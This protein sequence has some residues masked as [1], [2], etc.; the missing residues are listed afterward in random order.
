MGFN[1]PASVLEEEQNNTEVVE[2]TAT[3]PS[4]VVPDEPTDNVNKNTKPS[5]NI[6]TSILEDEQK[7]TEEPLVN[8]ADNSN[9]RIEEDISV[10]NDLVENNIENEISNKFSMLL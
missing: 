3:A 2:P 6:P 1:I 10:N 7:V 9:I 5:F 8:E 4:S